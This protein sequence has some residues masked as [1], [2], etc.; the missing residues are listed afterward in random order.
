[1]EHVETL[2][3]T[4]DILSPT[5]ITLIETLCPPAEK[6]ERHFCLEK[7]TKKQFLV[8]ELPC[9]GHY[10]HTECFKTWASASHT[11][12]T[13]HCTYCRT[14]Y[15]C[16]DTCFFCLQEYTE[17]LSCTMCCHTKVQKFIQNAQK[18]AQL[19]FRS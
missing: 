4:N 12:P 9:C 1:M 14:I 19:Y 15:Q 7:I 2:P 3:E 17:K 10:T 16:Q 13:V 18:T 11:K 8:F 6:E 5:I